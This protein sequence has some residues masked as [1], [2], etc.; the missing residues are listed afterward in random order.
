MT[1]PRATYRLQLNKDFTF[2]DTT[3]LV[4]YLDELGLSHAY[5]SP[6]LKARRGSTHG[7]DT[8][9]HSSEGS[10]PTSNG[11]FGAFSTHCSI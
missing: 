3:A 8:V 2:A 5:L 4:P 1:P 9:D 10:I 11:L 6:I 7:Y